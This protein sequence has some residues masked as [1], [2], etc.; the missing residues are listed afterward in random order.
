VKVKASGD[1]MDALGRSKAIVRR[2]VDE[3]LNAGRMEVVDDLYSAEMAPSVKGWIA[4]FRAAFPDVYMEIVDL[5][6]EGD[7]VVARFRCSGTHQG[8]WRGRPATGRRFENVDEV[9]IFTLRDDRIVAAWGVEDTL[10]R[11][12]QLGL[13]PD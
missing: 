1:G 3:V 7:K 10:T 8:E 9:Y 2:A 12:R 5:I 4:P 11:M 13:R 6:A